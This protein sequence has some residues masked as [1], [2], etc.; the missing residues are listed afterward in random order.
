M[1]RPPNTL[2][3][4]EAIF[5]TR[6]RRSSSFLFLSR[7]PAGEDYVLYGSSSGAPC[8][9]VHRRVLRQLRREAERATPNEIIGTLL[10][11]PCQDEKGVYVVVG[12]AVTAARDEFVGTPG[13]VRISA[14]GK[15]TLRH[16]AGQQFPMLEEV[17]WWHSH[18]R[19]MPRFSP[20][21]RNEQAT[22]HTHHV[23]IVV[24]VEHPRDE[25]GVYVGPEAQRLERMTSPADGARPSPPAPRLTSDRAAEATPPARGGGD[26]EVRKRLVS[27]AAV[28]TLGL[29]VAMIGTALWTQQVVRNHSTANSSP[30]S[31]VRLRTIR[32]HPRVRTRFGLVSTR[33]CRAGEQ[34]DLKLFVP[35]ALR[36]EAA[37]TSGDTEVATAQM[38][39]G[40][41]TVTVDCLS[42][43]RT[44]ISVGVADENGSSATVP[45]Q[46]KPAF[47]GGPELP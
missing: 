35:S 5:E 6:G 44:A 42:D 33:T 40:R 7:P 10:G 19:G 28:A 24:A 38:N 8:V 9:F 18:P 4:G 23:G 37:A 39:P 32:E 20:V 41:G 14:A 26:P 45:V 11:R 21:D 2:E 13:A 29:L 27:L 25:F 47:I 3:V 30:Q 36:S 1:T 22:Y 43:G 12:A 16:R 15:S 31:P 17:G 34:M 46:V